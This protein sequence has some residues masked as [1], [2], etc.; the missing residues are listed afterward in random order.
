[1]ADETG[2]RR[3]NKKFAVGTAAGVVTGAVLIVAAL[4]LV[5][6]R[7][8]VTAVPGTTSPSAAATP[9]VT[10][11]SVTP[12]IGTPSVGEPSGTPSA[13][14]TPSV[15]PSAAPTSTKT[16]TQSS[17]QVLTSLPR[18]SYV[19]VFKW[20]PKSQYAAAEAA[21]YAADNARGGQDVVA[22]D[23]NLIQ[24][25]GYWGIG[26]ANLA[27]FADATATCKAMGFGT[28][29]SDCFRRAVL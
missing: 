23:G 24:K 15:T 7:T 19:A 11:P 17:G 10:T 1:M 9:T 5:Q 2:G 4:N 22:I 6:P 3:G 20:L 8:A 21:Q 12:P 26:V 28:T 14:V 29:G 13:S 18:L 25:A 27:D 16:T